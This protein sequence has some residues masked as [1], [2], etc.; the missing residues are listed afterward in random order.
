MRSYGQRE[1]QAAAIDPQ[2]ERLRDDEERIPPIGRKK[3]C[4]ILTPV[5]R[6]SITS[7]SAVENFFR[8]RGAFKS[9]MNGAWQD[10]LIVLFLV[11]AWCWN[12]PDN[13]PAKLLVYPLRRF[14]SFFGLW[15]SWNMFAPNPIRSS[16]RLAVEVRYADGSRYEWRPPGT[17]PETFWQAFLHARFRKFA[18]NVRAG[19]I[20]S[21]Q[22]SLADYALRRLAKVV[23]A[24][25]MATHVSIVE[26]I[27]TIHLGELPAADAPPIRKT[28]FERP[29]VNGG[30]S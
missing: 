16:R 29:V 12:A 2:K 10:I 23:P 4:S 1:R 15:H 21:L 7:E 25:A 13:S 27:W 17:L 30:L 3:P 19:K 8:N 9:N 11:I 20:K 18:E 14:V 24:G 26:E 22:A 6:L 28:V 5:R